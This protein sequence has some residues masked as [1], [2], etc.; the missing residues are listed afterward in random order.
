MANAGKPVVRKELVAPVVEEKKRRERQ[1]DEV[2]EI[3]SG[4]GR[5]VKRSRGNTGAVEEQS[6]RV[7]A[8]APKDLEEVFS[9]LKDA[10]L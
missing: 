3:F 10:A 9:A 5:A 2:D 8:S 6:N 1:V 4:G 7:A